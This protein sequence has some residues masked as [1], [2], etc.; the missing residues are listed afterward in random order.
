MQRPAIIGY[1]GSITAHQEN[2]L[3]GMKDVIK[4]GYQGIHM[5][6]QMTRDDKMILF[7]DK[8]FLRLTGVD[9]T[10]RIADYNSIAALSLKK[11]IVSGGNRTFTYSSTAKIPLLENVL[12]EVK[13][14][15]LLIYI[16]LVPTDAPPENPAERDHALRLGLGV[17]KLIR[18]LKMEDEVFV[19][20]SDPFKLLVLNHENSNIVSGWWLKKEFYNDQIAGKM[21]K[22]F[23]DL[24]GLRDCYIKTAPTGI[25]FLPFLYETG[26][27]TKSVNGSIF[28]ASFDVIGNAKYFDGRSDTTKSILQK[29]YNRKMSY[30]AILAYYED[31]VPRDKKKDKE[32]LSIEVKRGLD[33][34]L[35]DDLADVYT[36]LNSIQSKAGFV[37]GS[38]LNWGCDVNVLIHGT[39]LFSKKVDADV[40]TLQECSA[41]LK[42]SIS[43]D[44]LCES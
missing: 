30:G 2:T 3:E 5:Q 24:N 14:K 19:V 12:N 38:L 40:Q 27:V 42:N 41:K 4:K 37:S 32:K 35:T 34:I 1:K 22:E 28:D 39:S 36:M 21:R 13:G 6:V 18:K 7:G 9:A 26:I 31:L 33:R 8:N 29:N 25:K 15:G 43:S 11:K 20:S 16:E 17:G 44:C 10:V 23:T